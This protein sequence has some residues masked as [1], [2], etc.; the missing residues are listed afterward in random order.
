MWEFI[1]TIITCIVIICVGHFLYIHI[2]THYVKNTRENILETQTQ[3]YKNV[4]E[5]LN[6]NNNHNNN[7]NH[8]ILPTNG[9]HD[10]DELLNVALNEFNK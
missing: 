5:S 10:N 1:Q 3:Q 7:D 4:I 9:D 6:N 2:Q 8:N